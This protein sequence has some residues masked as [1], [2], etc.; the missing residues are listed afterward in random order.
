MRVHHLDPLLAMPQQVSRRAGSDFV[1]AARKACRLNVHKQQK[2]AMRCT[3]LMPICPLRRLAQEAGMEGG[4]EQRG[5]GRC[6]YGIQQHIASL[7]TARTQRKHTYK[8]TFV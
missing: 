4:Q 1:L 5:S 3:Y 7:K 2:P 8:P 6:L